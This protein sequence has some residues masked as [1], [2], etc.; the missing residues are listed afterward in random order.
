MRK[1]HKKYLMI[2]ILALALI[3]FLYW[4]NFLPFCIFAYSDKCLEVSQYPDYVYFKW[5]F[6]GW[7]RLPS[8][9]EVGDPYTHQHYWVSAMRSDPSNDNGVIRVSI[10]EWDKVDDPATSDASSIKDYKWNE[11]VDDCV[12]YGSVRLRM[13]Y[14]D[15]QKIDKCP[16]GS[17]KRYPTYQVRGK[18]EVKVQP[19]KGYKGEYVFSGEIKFYLTPESLKAWNDEF[20]RCKEFEPVWSRIRIGNPITAEFRIPRKETTTIVTTTTTE[21]TQTTTTV[22]LSPQPEPQ[23]TINLSDFIIP[24]IGGISII[25]IVLWVKRR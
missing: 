23:P 15:G 9:L 19:K 20:S 18:C 1:K 8:S 6:E 12:Y 7:G 4:G 21:T 24:I 2:G 13:Y 5:W 22:T 11:W 16:G 25:G 10:E 3:G 17:C 14:C